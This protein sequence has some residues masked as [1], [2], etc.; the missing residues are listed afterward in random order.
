MHVTTAGYTQ[1]ITIE[2][3]QAPVWTT[4]SG[5]LNA[6]LQ[7]SDA[8]GIAAA[9]AQ[10]PVATDNCDADVTNIVKVSGAFVA[11]SC[12][13]AGTY[14]NT[15]T[16]TDACGNISAVYTQVITIEDTQAP[17]WTTASGALNATLQCSDAA[18][19]AAAQALFPVATDNCDADVTNIVK[20]SGGFIAGSCPEAGTYTNT[21][22]G[23]RCMWQYQCCLYSGH[24][25]R[26]YPGTGMDDS[27]R[28]AECDAQCS[29]AA[30]IAAAQALFPRS[31]R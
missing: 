7:C 30:G 6:T 18:G 22:D 4:A 11:G 3:T 25:Y 29:D 9:Q 8:A 28:S 21:L 20:V 23:N 16:V 1:V 10:F 5:A 15:W 27:I 14:T 13:E 17:V 31:N 19:I 12:P 26:R 2:D 24:H